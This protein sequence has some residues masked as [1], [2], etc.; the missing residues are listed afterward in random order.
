M[1]LTI[2]YYGRRLHDDES[3]APSRNTS[4]MLRDFKESEHPYYEFDA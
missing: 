4:S 2:A 1:E 3:M